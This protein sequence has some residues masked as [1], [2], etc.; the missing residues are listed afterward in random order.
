MPDYP[1]G[2]LFVG[3]QGMLIADY[4]HFKLCP[5]PKFADVKRPQLFPS[6]IHHHQEWITACKS[7]SP[8]GCH[9]GYSG[10]LAETVLLGTVAYR[11]GQKL[12]WD[13]VNLKATNCPQAD[14]FIRREYRKGWTL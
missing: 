12:T 8:T 14:R 11:A 9:F 10:P 3:S 2:V 7:G 13:P 1:E 4:G 6:G 5:E